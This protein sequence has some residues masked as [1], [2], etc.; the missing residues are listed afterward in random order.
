MR[1]G[2]TRGR[3]ACHRPYLARQGRFDFVWAASAVR[4]PLILVRIILLAYIT[5]IA[6]TARTPPLEV[7]ECGACGP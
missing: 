3:R 5:A 4:Q 1:I 7:N 2:E 6:P